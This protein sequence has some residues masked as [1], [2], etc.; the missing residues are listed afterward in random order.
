MNAKQELIEH[1]GNREVKYV[2]IEYYKDRKTIAGTLS[3]VLPLLYFEYDEG[4][5]W[6]ELF[7]NIWYA[8]GTWSERGEYNGKEWWVHKFCP[9]IPNNEVS[10]V[11]WRN[12]DKTAESSGEETWRPPMGET[13]K[14]RPR[15]I[16]EGFFDRFITGK[17]IDVGCG[18][19]PVTLECI[20]WDKDKSVYWDGYY[21]WMSPAIDA[22]ILKGIDDHSLDYVY[23]S[24]CLE[25]LENPWGALREWWRV[26]RPG[27]HLILYLPHRDLFELRRTLPSAG[28]A[29]HRWFFLP[30]RDEPPVTLGLVPLVAGVCLDSD[31]IYCRKCDEGYTARFDRFPGSPD[32]I[33]VIAEG[34]FSLEAVW[35]KR[36]GVDE[37]VY[38]EQMILPEEP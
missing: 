12:V 31:L 11:A 13:S 20:K 15:R 5:G 37:P 36:G 18:N 16:R 33:R 1:I 38:I 22:H 32:G 9:H 35:R 10:G 28:N 7:G 8:D 27:G 34:E 2:H 19:D 3:E 26:I 14:A 17:G 6:Q 30:D 23:S 29:N 24:H 25:D 4:F 21:S